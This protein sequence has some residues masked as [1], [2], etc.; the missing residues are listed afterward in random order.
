MIAT[1]RD[2]AGPVLGRRDDGVEA[3]VTIRSHFSFSEGNAIDVA[4]LRI[5][6]SPS[7][8]FTGA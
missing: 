8:D 4:E 2:F 5:L 6:P 3:G 7:A 1:S